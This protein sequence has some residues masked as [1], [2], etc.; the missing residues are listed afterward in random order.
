[1]TA[2]RGEMAG[3]KKGTG[4]EKPPRQRAFEIVRRIA[5]V[6]FAVFYKVTTEGIENVPDAGAAIICANH[7]GYKDLLLI[8]MCVRRK[9]RWLA[10]SELFRNPAFGALIT[11]LGAFP[12]ERGTGDR[13][14]I[15]TVYEVLGSGEIVGIF[16]EGRRVRGP[17]DRPAAK[18][19]FVSFALNARAPLVPVAI[20][21]GDGPLGAGKLFSRIHISFGE[22]V[23]LDY[24]KKYGRDELGDIG[25]GIMGAIYARIE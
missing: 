10:K 21:Y 14:A 15:K 20:K 5:F 12:V 8:G 24:G 4:G 17:D 1:M 16:P 11:C 3:S 25:A 9:V 23:V 6:L 19:G 22:K 13:G 7:S 18:R 2:D